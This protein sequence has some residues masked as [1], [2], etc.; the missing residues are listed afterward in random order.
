MQLD[1]KTACQDHQGGKCDEKYH[2][3]GA[4]TTRPRCR[5]KKCFVYQKLAKFLV[6]IN[7][8]IAK[9]VY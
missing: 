6:S 2:K 8:L 4:L 1:F 5:Q 7:I 9:S 3:H